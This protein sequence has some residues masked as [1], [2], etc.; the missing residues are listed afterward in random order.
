MTTQEVTLSNGVVL[1]EI[2]ESHLATVDSTWQRLSVLRLLEIDKVA[3]NVVGALQDAYDRQEVVQRDFMDVDTSSLCE[4]ELAD[5]LRW[6]MLAM[7]AEMI[8]L[9]NCVQWKPWAQDI[10]GI[11]SSRLELLDEAA[12]VLCFF[13]N[14][15]L[16]LK[17]T[18]AELIRQHHLKTMVNVHRQLDG[19]DTWNKSKKNYLMIFF[20]HYGP[21][22]WVCEFCGELVLLDQLNVHHRDHDHS[23]NEPKNLV[24]SHCACHA[25][26]HMKDTW[27]KSSDV[28]RQ[29]AGVK[30]S[31]VAKIRT[32]SCPV[33][34][35]SLTRGSGAA[36]HMIK[37]GVTKEQWP[38]TVKY[39]SREENQEIDRLIASRRDRTPTMCQCGAGPFVGSSGVRAHASLSNCGRALDEPATA[40]S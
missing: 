37:C 31:N 3:S 5:Y 17:I 2:N 4:H 24:A 35:R 10:G 28:R 36:R 6:N 27:S 39:R 12:D 40:T 22:P 38:T 7:Q 20:A 9:L 19:Y 25:S 18:P 1:S 21:G 23:N 26:H 29:A 15:L 30:M 14:I 13:L 33:C 11:K 32:V 16:A 34:Q 8:E